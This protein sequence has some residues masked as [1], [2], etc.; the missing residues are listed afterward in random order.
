MYDVV[1]IH[2]GYASEQTIGRYQS[3][4]EAAAVIRCIRD[5]SR[6]PIAPVYV[7]PGL[8]DSPVG[9]SCPRVELG[10]PIDESI[11]DA[12][13]GALE[14]A[15]LGA[16]F[17]ALSVGIELLERENDSEERHDILKTMRANI[18]RGT[19]VLWRI[20]DAT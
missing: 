7:R 14:R 1:A 15:K 6:L 10:G 4:A 5:H 17:T 3:L 8:E 12:E 20:L 2:Q 13:L 11:A 19:Q 9:T 16:T 18:G